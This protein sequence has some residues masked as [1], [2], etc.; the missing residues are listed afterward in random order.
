MTTATPIS[1]L[2]SAGRLDRTESIPLVQTGTTKKIAVSDLFGA[3]LASDVATADGLTA[4]GKF[5]QYDA[6]QTPAA[7]AA[8][9]SAS[10]A[11]SIVLGLPYFPY[12]L[13]AGTSASGTNILPQGITTGTVGGT[14][15]AGA[16]VGT[17]AL[18]PVGGNFTGVVANLVV[19]SATAATIQIVNP[20]RTT[21]ASPTAPTWAN[22]TGATIPAGTT[23][24]ANIGAQIGTG[25]NP[26]YTTSDSSGAYLLYWQN[27]GTG[28]PVAVLDGAGAQLK[29]PL[30]ATVS[31]LSARSPTAFFAF[32]QSGFFMLD[33]AGNAV[34]ILS[35][36]LSRAMFTFGAPVMIVDSIGQGLPVGGTP[37][38]DIV[39]GVRRLMPGARSEG[40][41][42]ICVQSAAFDNTTPQTYQSMI[43]T[44]QH[45]DAIRLVMA[46]GGAS[47]IAVSSAAVSVRADTNPTDNNNS[48]T[49]LPVTFSGSASGSIPIAPGGSRVGYLVSDWIPISSIARIDGGT[50]GV[51]IARAY[52]SSAASITIPNPYN[53]NSATRSGGFAFGARVTAGDCVTTITNFA[54]VTN[55][56]STPICGVNY[57]ARGIVAC[58]GACGDSITFGNSD[59][60]QSDG[61][62]V[63]L[64]TAFNNQALIAFDAVNLGWSSTQ[65]PSF[66]QRYQD[67]VN[68]GL[69]VDICFY[70]GGSPNDMGTGVGTVTTAKINVMR[71]NRAQALRL[72][73]A[74]GTVPI[75]WTWGPFGNTYTSGT[76]FA[77]GSSDSLRVAD[78]A[79]IV[80]EGARG[81]VVA[82][83]ATA[84]YGSTDGTGQ[85]QPNPTYF[86]VDLVHPNAAGYALR[87]TVSVPVVTSALTA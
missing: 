4:Q 16:T 77:W 36:P 17:Y 86:G 85:Q 22:P 1:A 61:D 50:G 80:A 42:I 49:W 26:N 19:T 69:R 9:A 3:I 40:L 72:M 57:A 35:P 71:Q 11:A 62:V 52:V 70:A 38:F 55:M 30:A 32:G 60:I 45:F 87:A 43:E 2:P 58:V 51:L 82:D 59:A 78:N 27:T 66:F 39:K 44:A 20:G 23:L 29:Y 84:L 64:A 76:Y 5:S 34:P 83:F 6:A 10:L 81:F 47:P 79:E 63:R 7:L 37:A 12:P 48:A 46:N 41:R 13:N 74:Q 25:S 68:A 73:R 24:T 21:S 14:A 31:L 33:S 53:T 54:S 67:F 15:I 65:S 75:L 18:T 28:A 8:A 56:A